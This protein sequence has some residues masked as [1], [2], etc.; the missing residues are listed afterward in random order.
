MLE[1]VVNEKSPLCNKYIKD[2]NT[3]EINNC[4]YN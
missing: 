3:N 1:V 4:M 2:I